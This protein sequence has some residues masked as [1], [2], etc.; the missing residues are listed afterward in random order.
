M[1]KLRELQRARDAEA[2]DERVQPLAS[3]ELEI[4]GGVNEIET[5]HPT[6]N[7]GAEQQRSQS[8]P[9]SRG[10]P[11]SRRRDGERQPEEKMARRGKALRQGIKKYD[12]EG[13]RREHESGTS[14]RSRGSKK[15]QR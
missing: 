13:E 12:S 9:A 14:D 3:I 1:K 4:L 11:R 5:R 7:A 10:D 8:K 6:E 2:H 15:R